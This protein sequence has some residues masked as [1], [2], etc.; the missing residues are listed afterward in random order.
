MKKCNIVCGGVIEDIAR[1]AA[2]V[3][4]EAYTICADS[5]YAYVERL[6]LRA[7]AVLGDFDS[8]DRE[9]VCAEQV[10]VF[11]V[12]KDYTDSEIA[13][14]HALELG[15][16]DITLLGALGGRIDHALGNIHL[17]AYAAQRGAQATIIDGDTQLWYSEDS[18][19]ING[20]P[21][22]L[23]SVIPLVQGGSYTTDG[24]EYPLMHQPLPLT[25]ISNVFT[26]DFARI[27]AENAKYL[28]IHICK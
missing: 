21:G 1:T 2:R 28:V 24:L 15:Y 9:Q 23:L 25:G 17:L 12:R 19:C 5:G 10:Q 20:K 8:F 4:K 18:V 14:M 6:G 3:D 16:T 27:C 26:A 22:D 11:P 7:D 13:L